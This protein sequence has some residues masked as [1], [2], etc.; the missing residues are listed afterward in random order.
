MRSQFSVFSGIA[1]A[2][3]T[4]TEPSAFRFRTD[5]SLDVLYAS[6]EKT[7]DLPC[8]RIHR[9]CPKVND[10]R[11]FGMKDVALNGT[12]HILHDYSPEV[13]EHLTI[14]CYQPEP[15]YCACVLQAADP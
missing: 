15:G 9:K 3:V 1:W 4:S 8:Y 12:K 6:C 2:V 5:R 7:F 13:D 14:H 11:T 10:F